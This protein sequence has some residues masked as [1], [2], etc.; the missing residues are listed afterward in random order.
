MNSTFRPLPL[1]GRLALQALPAFALVAALAAH[2]RASAEVVAPVAAP[3]AAMP[4][5][6]G[7][8]RYVAQQLSGTKTAASGR[9]VAIE[10]GSLDARLRLK[11][12]SHIEAFMPASSRAWGKTH[13]GVRCNEPAGWTVFVPVDVHVFGT[14]AVANR[15]L[16][17]GQSL[18]AGDVSF[19]ERDLTRIA[20]DVVST[21][22]QLRDRVMARSFAAGQALVA[23]GLRAQP[24][25]G[26]GDAVK[27]LVDGD[28]FSI[29]AA[30]VA[31]SQADDGAPVRV[32]LDSGRFVQ[33]IARE[34]RVVQVKL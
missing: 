1:F 6:A 5:S 29:E 31:L 21:E 33:G 11:A 20:G 8:E 14:V 34:G 26:N 9:R 7:I 18:G 25:L 13:I 22:A 19:E 3:A 17:P 28:G 2:G 23:T 4:D 12:C 24:V 30:G 10:V 32:R 16:A 27:V 15:P